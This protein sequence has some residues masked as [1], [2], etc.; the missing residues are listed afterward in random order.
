LALAFERFRPKIIKLIFGE[1]AS[2]PFVP[3]VSTS[4]FHT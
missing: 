4:G 2:T 3:V 1:P